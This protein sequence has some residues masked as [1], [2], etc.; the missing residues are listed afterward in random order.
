MSETSLQRGLKLM[1]ILAQE[2]G[3]EQRLTDLAA[4]AELTQG[5]AHRLVQTL[6]AEGFVEQDAKSRRYR[7]GLDFFALAAR[8]GNP[9]NLRDLC[10]PVLL[11]LS[12]SLGDTVFLMVR[13]GFDALCLDRCDGPFPVGSLTGDIGGK[14]PLG[15]GQGSLCI[16]ANLPDAEGEEVLRYNLP[17]MTQYGFM[18]EV[19]LRT[20]IAQARHNGYVMRADRVIPGVAGVGVPIL[21]SAGRP[22]AALSIGTLTER[23]TAERLPALVQ[24]LKREAAAIGASL[25]PLDPALRRPAQ[26]LSGR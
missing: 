23:V 25:N 2:G 15:V 9:G 11:R 1:R 20:E 10:R 22:V 3:A 5:T 6:V 8:A 7:L 26:M 12:A 14:V 16:L 17:R 24:I 21:D 18:D 4:A 19:Y 13:A